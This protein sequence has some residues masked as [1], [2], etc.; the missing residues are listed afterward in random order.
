ME[1]K[2][3]NFIPVQTVDDAGNMHQIFINTEHVLLVRAEDDTIIIKLTN[4]EIIK[5]N[6]IPIHLFMDKFYR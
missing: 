3:I 4:G 2:K 1:H 6:N 5:V